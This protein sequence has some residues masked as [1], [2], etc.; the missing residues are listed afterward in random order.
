MKEYVRGAVPALYP[1]MLLG[2]NRARRVDARL[3]F[4]EIRR[5]TGNLS[6]QER[7]LCIV[8]IVL[9]FWTWLA[10]KLNISQQPKLA[11]IEY[12]AT[13]AAGADKRPEELRNPSILPRASSERWP[14][15]SRNRAV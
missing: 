11:R 10:T 5:E 4:D 14:A 6:L 7:L 3:L 9:A 13:Y 2:P 15:A 8:A 12:P 1:A